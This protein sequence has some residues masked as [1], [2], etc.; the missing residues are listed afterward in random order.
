MISMSH[1][2]DAWHRHLQDELLLSGITE[3]DQWMASE[4]LSAD[5]SSSPNNDLVRF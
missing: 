1:S 4:G 3:E 2:E 5:D